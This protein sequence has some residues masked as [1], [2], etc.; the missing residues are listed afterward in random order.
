MSYLFKSNNRFLKLMTSAMTWRLKK[1]EQELDFKFLSLLDHEIDP[2]KTSIFVNVTKRKANDAFLRLTILFGNLVKHFR[3][4]AKKV[5]MQNFNYRP[6]D[7]SLLIDSNEAKRLKIKF[8]E[9][10]TIY[11]EAL[12]NLVEGQREVLKNDSFRLMDGETVREKEERLEGL[13]IQWKNQS[14]SF[15]N[16]NNYK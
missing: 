11:N 9:F 1:T 10:L 7:S 8:I 4:F 12:E 3:S 6:S 13:L 2:S 5:N 15:L 14:A 16:K